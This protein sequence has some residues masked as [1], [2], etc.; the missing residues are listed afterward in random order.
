MNLIG[1]ASLGGWSVIHNVYEQLYAIV[2]K[3][4]IL[5]TVLS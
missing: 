2:F 5:E 4:K 3:N 1:L